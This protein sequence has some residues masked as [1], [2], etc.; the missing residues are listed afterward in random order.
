MTWLAYVLAVIA[1]IVDVGGYIALGGIFTAHISGDTVTAAAEAANRDWIAALEHLAPVF[2]LVAGYMLGGA[3]IRLAI[4]KHVPYWFSIGAALEAAFLA[5]FA[6]A[7][8]RLAAGSPTY[9]PDRWTLIGL[10]A[11]LTL[12]MG[13]QNA[14][15]NNVREVTVRTTFVTGMIINFANA[16]LDW[17]FAA[18][19]GGNTREQREKAGIYAAVWASFAVG[20]CLG[21]YLQVLYGGIVFLLP[22]FAM[23]GLALYAVRIPAASVKPGV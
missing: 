14:L 23:I 6:V 13:V 21:G 10:M 1:G 12:A 3:I 15:L 17:T 20:G 11:C 5:I 8:H 4:M 22:C 7:H 9:V 2:L 19:T 16:L 18:L